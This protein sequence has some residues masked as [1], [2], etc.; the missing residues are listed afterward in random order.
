MNDNA[1]NQ[2]LLYIGKAVV[3]WYR[4]NA[5]SLPWRADREPYH[6]W[7]SE[8]MLQQTRVEAVIGYYL[9]F[10]KALPDIVSLANEKEDAVLKLW[11]GLGYYNRARNLQKAAKQIVSEYKGQFPSSYEQIRSLPG[12]GDYTAGAIGSICF[13]LPTPAIDGNVLRVLSR[14]FEDPAVVDLPQTKRNYFELLLPLYAQYNCGELT[15]GMMELGACVCVPNGSPKCGECPLSGACAAAANSS[16][17]Q[18]PVR[19]K[20]NPRRI[21]NRIVLILQCGDK[22][23]LLK[24]KASGLLANLWEFP[25]AL[26]DSDLSDPASELT[27]KAVRL[28]EELKAEPISLYKKKHYTHIFTHVEWDMTAF[29]FRCRNQS[30]QLVWAE[31]QETEKE[32]ALPSA[33]KTFLEAIE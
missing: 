25:N 32:F 5:R 22:I 7:I 21:E 24:R 33:F 10:L 9:R 26:V 27:E 23:A 28:A 1:K 16:W 30:D 31:K 15:Q 2:K 18:F 12:I 17:R 20:K 6:V 13:G 3:P 8:I 29:Y 11:E 4:H 14:Y 19:A